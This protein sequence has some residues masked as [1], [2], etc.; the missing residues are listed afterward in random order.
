MSEADISRGKIFSYASA[1]EGIQ[2]GWIALCREYLR[3]QLLE[4]WNILVAELGLNYIDM[5]DGKI[6]DL[7]P[8]KVEWEKMYSISEETCLSSNDAMLVNVLRCSRFP[9]IA[10]A[11]FDI[12]YA[13]LS[14]EPSD[15]SVLVPDT[16][17]YKKIKGLRF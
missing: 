17:F 8:E 6:S 14:R 16:L 4:A 13:T 15:K 5:R 1:G 3:G 2:I 12:A 11:D 9:F 7:I 10:S